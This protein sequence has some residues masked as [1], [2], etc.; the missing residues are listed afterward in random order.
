MAFPEVVGKTIIKRRII[1]S[2]LEQDVKAATVITKCLLMS[3]N[4]MWIILVPL[5]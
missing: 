2:E 3:Q 5:L 4:A 1:V